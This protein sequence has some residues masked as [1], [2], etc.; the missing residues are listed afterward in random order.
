LNQG[1]HDQNGLRSTVAKR[2][3][4]QIE[5]W[6][7]VRR[8]GV[9]HFEHSL[10]IRIEIHCRP[11]AALECERLITVIPPPVRNPVRQS[12]GF[13]RPKGKPL[14]IHLR[15]QGARGDEALFIL[16]VMNVQW[17]ALPMSWYGPAKSKHRFSVAFLTPDLQDLTCV[18]VDQS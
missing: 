3:V 15:R 1:R 9:H 2:D 8:S 6:R 18:S 13:A 10:K 14:T 17:R 5:Q 4:G 7:T 16:K 12:D 11:R